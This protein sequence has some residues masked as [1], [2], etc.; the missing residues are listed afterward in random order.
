VL[1][2]DPSVAGGRGDVELLR[3]QE[4]EPRGVQVGAA[5]DYAVLRQ[6]RYLP[7][8]VGKH[9]HGVGHDNEDRVRA[10]LHQVGHDA[11]EDVGV[12]LD[13]VQSG[14]ALALTRPRR[15][16]A[17]A[18]VG[19][20]RV[21]SACVYSRVRE[22]GAAVLQVQHLALQLLPHHIDQHH[23][24]RNVLPTS[25][26]NARALI[27]LLRAEPTDSRGSYNRYKTI[28]FT[29]PES[30]HTPCTLLAHSLHTPCTL[31]AHSTFSTSHCLLPIEPIMLR[32]MANY[33]YNYASR[34]RTGSSYLAKLFTLR[35]FDSFCHFI[36]LSA[37]TP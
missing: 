29:D 2:D 31:L 21:I 27:Q 26:P 19:R 13:Q 33:A 9:V 35:I 22:E 8:D 7:G 3:E 17:D 11:L 28:A 25:M 37:I 24:A 32:A 14:L 30:L 12:A 10:V 1:A 20:G 18:R 16:Y 6:S 5:S 4:S 34:N 15:Y 23:V 36:I